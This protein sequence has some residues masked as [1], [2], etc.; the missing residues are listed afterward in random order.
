MLTP[1][2]RC[3]AGSLDLELLTMAVPCRVTSTDPLVDC[4][5]FVLA[6]V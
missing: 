3:I 4:G 6:G 1:Q 5:R 2:P